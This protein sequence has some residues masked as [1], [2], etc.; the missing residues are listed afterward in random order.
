MS[1]SDSDSDIDIEYDS[2]LKDPDD[3][4]KPEPQPT[5]V[6][7]AR[8]GKEG[9]IIK[10]R[11]V[12]SHPLWA[13]YLW[14]GGRMAADMIEDGRIAVAGKRV[15]EFGAGAALPSIV[16]VLN[17]AEYVATTDY[18]EEVLLDDIRINLKNNLPADA[19][20]KRIEV[21]GLLWGS[22]VDD[23]LKAGTAPTGEPRKYDV[24]ILADLLANH[25]A[26]PD[27]A[28]NLGELM[29]KP[30]GVAY[31]AFG[32]HR[33]WL[34][35]RDLK[36]FEHATNQGMKCEEIFQKHTTPM[37]ENDPGSL[38]VRSTVHVYKITWP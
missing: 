18:P 22:K 4:Y 32:H 1:K 37:F 15:F 7:Y 23:L 38:D 28:K 9:E 14:N 35:D 3:F 30:N 25:T 8:P 27:L 13:H 11:L 5:V 33:P 17:G 10:L 6:E 21:Y 24:L 12:G 36:F 16:S 31:V 26:L 29:D 34:A 2:F 19:L 20:G